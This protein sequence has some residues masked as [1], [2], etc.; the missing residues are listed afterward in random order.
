M[1]ELKIHQQ[2]ACLRKKKGLTQEE[3]AKTLGVTNQA[4]SKWESGQCCPDIQL[5]PTLAEL[6]QVSVDELLGHPPLF[7]TDA[8]LSFLRRKVDSLPE[9]QDL[10]FAFHMSAA[11]HAFLFSKSMRRE[12]PGWDADAS[13]EHAANAE[14][15]YSCFARPNYATLMQQGCVLFSDNRALF[16]NGSDLCQI[17]SAIKPFANLCNLKIAYALYQLTAYSETARATSAQISEKCGLPE[18]AVKEAL[19]GELLQFLQEEDDGYRFRGMYL[20]L[21][22]VISL[23]NFKF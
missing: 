3:L 5:L 8:A 16:M 14:W 10:A 6:F 1:S 12:I 2:I 19:A 13:A 17:A 4:V 9:G 7:P 18:D 22:P 21:M 20:C 15:G 11:L 23:M